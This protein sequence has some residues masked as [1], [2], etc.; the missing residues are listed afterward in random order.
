MLSPVWIPIG[1]IFSILQT[2]MQLPLLSLTTSYSSSFHPARLSSMITWFEYENDFSS[3][4]ISSSSLWANP[5]QS[6]PRA[7]AALTRTGYPIS[8]AINFASL[9]DSAVL[10]FAYFTCISSRIWLNFFL[11]SVASITEVGVQRTF[12]LCFLRVPFVSSVNQ[13]LSAVCPQKE[14]KIASG[15]SFSIILSTKWGVT[16]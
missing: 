14:S 6:H 9:I 3:N 8:E 4:L 10:L 7:K 1:S 15:F 13:Q 5:L 12:T 2:V 16:G 11:S